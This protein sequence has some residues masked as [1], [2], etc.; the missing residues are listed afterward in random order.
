MTIDWW[1]IGLQAVN[2]LI[3]MWLLSRVFWRPIAG[4]ISRRK[5][6]VQAMIDAARETQEKADAALADVARERAGIAAEREAI[7][8]AAKQEA[9][10][11]TQAALQEAREKTEKILAA[12][13]S[14]LA[15]DRDRVYRQSVTQAAE[16]STEIA[17]KLLQRLGTSAIQEAFLQLLLDAIGAM[18]PNEKSILVQSPDGIELVCAIPPAEPEQAKITRA[19]QQA[20]G[21][22][23]TI[24]FV[25]DPDLIAG[26]EIR[27]AHFTLHNSWKSDLA[28]ILKELKNAA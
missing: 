18:P 8:I 15:R 23:L 19:I 10:K 11:A 27:T 14:R 7:L 9:D 1:T 2:F 25:T 4:A 28:T 6:A 26:M 12:E 20:L 17:A 21:G 5:D 24:R 3:L 22:P 16:L 13:K